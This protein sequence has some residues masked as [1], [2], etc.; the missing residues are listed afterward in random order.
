MSIFLRKTGRVCTPTAYLLKKNQD[1]KQKKTESK[2]GGR[3]KTRKK[4]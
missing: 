2:G 4:K 1:T 3:V